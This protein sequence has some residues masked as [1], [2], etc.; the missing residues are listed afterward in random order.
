MKKRSIKTATLGF[1][2]FVDALIDSEGIP[3]RLGTT[4]T[5]AWQG[6][7]FNLVTPRY[8]E[9]FREQAGTVKTDWRFTRPVPQQ[10]ERRL[11]RRPATWRRRSR[12]K[13]NCS[14]FLPDKVPVR[15]RR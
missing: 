12:Q 5:S 13:R 14:T 7:P 3:R 1:H 9:D 2:G 15:G 8:D 10:E 6:R 11:P 4:T